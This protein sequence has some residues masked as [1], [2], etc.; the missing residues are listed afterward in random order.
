MELADLSAERIQR[1]CTQDSITPAAFLA[2]TKSAVARWMAASG[3][4]TYKLGAKTQ[5]DVAGRL[6]AIGGLGLQCFPREVRGLLAHKYCW[7]VDMK[8][9]QPR[10][11]MQ[12]CARKGWS[13]P[14]L[15][16]YCHRRDE[17]LATIISSTGCNRDDAKAHC[18]GIIF[19]MG[20]AKAEA[21][22][23]PV[24][25]T[26]QLQPELRQLR[27]LAWDD[28]EYS[29]L[30]AAC[31][32][33][34]TQGRDK[35][36]SL[37]AIICQ[38]IERDCLLSLEVSLGKQGRVMMTYIHDGGLVHKLDGETEFPPHILR[39][40]EDYVLQD[41]GYTIQ[42][43]IKAMETS[44]RV[45]A[46]TSDQY[47]ILKRRL[48]NEEGVGLVRN[49]GRFL[50]KT[51]A[52]YQRVVQ[53]H[54]QTVYRSWKFQRDGRDRSFI[55]A[56][57]EDPLQQSW[58]AV[59][60]R[61]SPAP[62]PGYFNLFRGFAFQSLLTDHCISDADDADIKL[63]D[64]LV[65][66]VTGGSADYFWKCLA[67]LLQR[68]TEKVGLCF[69]FAGESG[70]GKD[71]LLNWIGAHLLREGYVKIENAA[72]DLFGNFNCKL[73]HAFFVHVEEASAAAFRDHA[74]F[75]QFKS[76]ITSPIQTINAKNVE[77]REVPSFSTFF[78]STNR[79]FAVRVEH[80]DRRFV[81]FQASAHEHKADRAW[82]SDLVERISKPEVIKAIAL[83]LVSLDI[84][85]FD[86]IRER[87]VSRLLDAAR[88]DAIPLHI[89][90]LNHLA[91]RETWRPLSSG[92][93]VT[94]ECDAAQN[95]TLRMSSESMYERFSS[96]TQ[97]SNGQMSKMSQKLLTASLKAN[98]ELE[99][100]GDRPIQYSKL[101]FGTTTANGF[102]I[103]LQLL[104]QW[105]RNKRFVVDS[106]D[107]IDS[108]T[109]G[110]RIEE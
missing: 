96:W 43:E 25:F 95:I 3:K 107:D 37:L 8:N 93:T 76:M 110:I 34:H 109:A 108:S 75:E 97:N 53:T 55:D 9:A 1:R 69:V 7:D 89:A 22:G 100:N 44:L 26:Q 2:S 103:R 39:Y 45:R 4:V 42:L 38:T 70:I 90:F 68:P 78:L 105:L 104:K 21:A 99:G 79:D 41:I 51:G 27:N 31:T 60:W 71:T 66:R 18:T 49:E 91:F 17:L 77:V 16:Q 19:G 47:S 24:F 72:R 86:P 6:C 10:I 67:R 54:L 80:D 82:F 63:L 13:C 62:S 56:W 57:L 61:P 81:I 59:E 35:K 64:F 84:S 65:D 46:S 52:T 11:L 58:E 14:A 98:P 30:R 36:A 40:C 83:R 15:S 29:S 23:L 12:L 92:S 73:E 50:R 94:V 102:V 33:H 106:A 28:S 85:T 88:R 5:L 87:P 48:E 74:A 20:V 101:R 32:R